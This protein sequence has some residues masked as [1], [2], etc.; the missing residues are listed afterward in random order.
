MS[1]HHV[2]CMFS[3]IVELEFNG[4]VHTIKVILSQFT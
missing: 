2:H 3:G 4:L 1:T